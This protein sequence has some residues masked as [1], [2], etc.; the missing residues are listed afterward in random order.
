MRRGHGGVRHLPV[1]DVDAPGQ[2]RV[3]L[4]RGAPAAVGDLQRVG[5]RG[6]G[7][8]VGRGVGHR[9]GHVRD[10]VV[11]HA[12]LDVARVVVGRRPAGLGAPALVDGHVDERRPRLHLR[13]VR[14]GD[15][16]RRAGARD[17]HRAEN[18]IGRRDGALDVCR[19]RHERGDVPLDDVAHVGEAQRVDVDDR[20]VGPEPDAHDA[21]V[22]A[23]DTRADDGHPATPHARD[24]RQ[25]QPLAA[26]A[27]LE[28]RGPAWIDS[29]PATSDIGT[30]S[31][32][33][34]S[35][36]CTVS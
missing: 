8:R 33:V 12:L 30:S 32:S 36:S 4:R 28:R 2:R 34:P 16:A 31:G 22:Q 24:A 10:A 21:G 29:R 17:E 3:A 11:D 20:D 15:Q 35:E 27:H 5:H 13:Q 9:A 1:G 25:Q 23:D 19:V 14:T 18:E 26:R 7:Q 6:V